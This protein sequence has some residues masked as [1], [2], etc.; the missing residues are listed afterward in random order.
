MR[1]VPVR[2]QFVAA[3]GADAPGRGA[4]G[5]AGEQNYPHVVR[6]GF[7][8]RVAIE[9]SG[10]APIAVRGPQPALVLARLVLERPRPLL[11]DELADLLWPDALPDHWEGAARQVVSRSRRALTA[12]GLPATALQSTA[13]VTSLAIDE[14][15]EVDVELVITQ[16]M[17]AE[18]L[19]EDK[20]WD[21]A[22]DVAAGTL[23]VL[24]QPLLPTAECRWTL[25]WRDRLDAF[26]QRALRA[27]VAAALGLERS[28]EAHD[29]A[30]TALERDPFD[31]HATRLLMAACELA[32]NRA[33]ALR[34]YEQLRRRLDE[35]LG[36]RPADD[37][38]EEYRRLL[39]APPVSAPVV[40]RTRP[41]FESVDTG[42]FVGR[43]HELAVLG[44]RVARARDGR[45]EVVV[46]EGEAGIGKT[47]LI[48]E[49]TEHAD[50]RRELVLWGRCEPDIG[51]AH[52]P[53][54]DIV[55]QLLSDRPDV[56]DRL[57]IVGTHLA[58][59]VPVLVPE[60]GDAAPATP[61]QATA[62]LFRAVSSALI[63]AADV[64]L[65]IV[66]DD[67]QW[68]D[69]DTLA[70]LR[71]VV[72]RLVDRPCLVALALRNATP[73]IAETLAEVERLTT[74]TTLNLAG[75]SVDD[76]SELLSASRVDLPGDATE[77]A[78]TVTF[79]TAGNP[80]YVTQLVRE[81]EGSGMPF[82][83][84]AL[85]SRV[86]RLLDRR[87]AALGDDL[88]SILTLAAVTGNEFD[89]ALLESCA[90]LEPDDVLDRVE[91]LCRR[92]L[93]AERGTGRFG[94]THALLRDA[95]LESV[96]ETRRARLHRRIAEALTPAG[97]PAMVARH[98]VAAGPSA[99]GEA[100]RW[101][102]RAGA[103]ALA[104]AGWASAREHFAAAARLAGNPE[105]RVDALVGLGR[106]QRALGASG[107]ARA[108]LE[109]AL[110]LAQLHELWRGVAAATLALVGGGGRGVAVDVPDAERAALLRTALSG[111]GDRDGDLLVPVLA[112]LALALALT[113]EIDER[114]ALCDRCLA[115]ARAG[116][117]ARSLA[118]ALSAR[119]VALMG[120][121]G[122]E[123]RVRD[124]REVLTLPV[125]AV[126]PELLIGAQLGLVEDLLE[127]GDRA[128][129]DG[130]LAAATAKAAAL[131]H[132]YWSWA[133]ACWRTLVTIIDGRLEAAEA[134]AFEAVVMQTEH[135]EAVAA[136][137]VNLVA[138]RCFQRRTAEM[139]DLL[140]AAADDNP[141]IPCYRAVLAM[142]A[143]D[144][145][146]VD[147]ARAAFDFFVTGGFVLPADSNWMLTAAVLADTCATLGDAAAAE[148]LSALLEPFADRQ[149]IL[150]CY[151]GGGSYWGPVAH[152]LGRL[153]SVRG[154]I[155]TAR[156]YLDAAVQSSEAFG[157]PLFAARSQAALAA[158]V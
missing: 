37:T 13:G 153:A 25:E 123:G 33:A 46:V 101:S 12:A 86:A 81:A 70:L 32:G 38:E 3:A 31:E 14:H 8:G 115:T 87:L 121:Q 140:R 139:L 59:I 30:R 158:L 117:D 53:F 132:P 95:V 94:F 61:E 34:A 6:F 155:P 16:V 68:A 110:A 24:R 142:C 79:R 96:S 76:V 20:D 154:E 65:T 138:V 145:G 62:R 114:G 107:E 60:S 66:I 103:E 100:V 109:D 135:P 152:H 41:R 92:H 143:A 99:A 144:A 45:C 69:D 93:L 157:A 52:G 2:H 128:G 148:R 88:G 91:E 55:T 84:N 10:A 75:L 146:D 48:L 35:E 56:V 39:G 1:V 74:T 126:P 11:R 90:A 19:I 124:G 58:P 26:E 77:V 130:A 151:G 106:A 51:V 127:I 7:L 5:P 89:L 82:D 120:P 36:V 141:N 102:Q 54:A 29:L 47:R 133:T 73:A 27:R 85:P 28:T 104:R 4:S 125:R 40:E 137:G 122:T 98:F 156:G 136:L 23:D 72:A 44:D 119:R 57:G 42:P 9:R 147:T 43:R 113:N 17:R 112:E 149:V 131:D 64:P 134:L 97:D 50:A 21:E 105:P 150:N 71:H 116:G 118:I 18:Q 108:T 78:A 22:A 83:P 67:L 111:L 15:I 129:A 80:L 49:E 63:A